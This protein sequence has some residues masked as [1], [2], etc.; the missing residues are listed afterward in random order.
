MGTH[1]ARDYSSGG[2]T[3]LLQLHTTQLR[4]RNHKQS[5]SIV[6]HT[7][8]LCGQWQHYFQVVQGCRAGIEP[9]TSH[10]SCSVSSL[11]LPLKLPLNHPCT[12]PLVYTYNVVCTMYV[13]VTF[14]AIIHSH[15]TVHVHQVTVGGGLCDTS[16]APSSQ[17]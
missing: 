16:M 15:C 17:S 6:L 14:Q 1:L 3:E 11:K 12:P 13:F 7:H 8:T 4:R 10:N 9:R 5:S 2:P